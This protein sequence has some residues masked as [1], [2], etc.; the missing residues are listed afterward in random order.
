MSFV[1]P[2]PGFFSGLHQAPIHRRNKEKQHTK[3]KLRTRAPSS[4]SFFCKR[5]LFL[6][7]HWINSGCLL[8]N[9]PGAPDFC[10]MENIGCGAMFESP[11]AAHEF[12][13]NF[14]FNIFHPYDS[15]DAI[16]HPF[17]SWNKY[18]HSLHGNHQY[19]THH[20]CG[21]YRSPWVFYYSSPA[22]FY[23]PF[24]SLPNGFAVHRFHK[25]KTHLSLWYFH[26]GYRCYT[27]FTGKHMNT[28]WK[29][30]TAAGAAS[31]K[32]GDHGRTMKW[33]TAQLRS[34]LRDE[35]TSGHEPRRQSEGIRMRSH[36]N[37]RSAESIQ[38]R[39]CRYRQHRQ[40]SR[41]EYRIW[42]SCVRETGFYTLASLHGPSERVHVSTHHI[43]RAYP[44]HTHKPTLAS[45]AEIFQKYV[46]KSLIDL[47]PARQIPLR[48][49]LPTLTLHT[50]NI[51]NLIGLSKYEMLSNILQSHNVT[52]L[53]LQETKSTSSNEVTQGPFRYLLSGT[54]AEP[55]A[56]VGFAIHFSLLPFIHDFHPVS[57]RLAVLI[58]NV[59]PRKIALFTVYAPSQ[60]A[61]SHADFERKHRFWDDIC[62][63]TQEYSRQH[64]VLLMGDW[65]TR[66]YPDH[67]HGM[68]DHIGPVTFAPFR[69]DDDAVVHTNLYHMFD[70]LSATDTCIV[71]S[72]WPRPLS[73]L[74][75]Y[76]EIQ[77]PPDASIQDPSP[78]HFAV[79]DHI[80]CPRHF[81][82]KFKSIL[83]RPL[84]TLPW[85]HRHFLLE[86]SLV[87]PVFE[88][89]PTPM[90]APTLMCDTR[91][92][93]SKLAFQIQKQIDL[94]LPSHSSAPL[95]SITA[96]HYHLYTD[97]SCPMNFSAI[98]NPAGWGWALFA[99]EIVDGYGPVGSGLPF[100]IPGSNN[101][102]ELQAPLEAFDYLFR[103]P[104]TLPVLVCFDSQYVLDILEGISVPESHLALIDLLFAALSHTLGLVP[105]SFSKVQ[106]HTGIPGN[107]RAD[108]NAAKGV[109]SLAPV[110][111]YVTVPAL[112]VLVRSPNIPSSFSSASISQQADHL[113]RIL[114]SASVA[115][116]PKK[117]IEVRKPYLSSNTLQLIS[118][119]TPSQQDPAQL[120][121]RKVI[122]KSAKRDRKRWLLSQISFDHRPGT[123]NQWR[124]I[125]FLRSVYQPRTKQVRF[126][127]GQLS[128]ANSKAEALAQHLASTVWNPVPLPPLDTTPLYEPQSCNLQPFSMSE[129]YR[130]LRRAKR[131][132][133]PGPDSISMDWIVFSP[134]QFKHLLLAHYN[135]CFFAADAP[136]NWRMARVAMIYKGK[137]K[138][139]KQ[140]GS[141]RAISLA[142]SLYK[143]YA[144]MLQH[145]LASA[146]DYILSPHQFGFRKSRSA[147]TPIFLV[148]RLL[149][150]FERRTAPL[151]LL[152][153]DW[154]QA[155]DSVSRE[156]VRVS[157]LRYG[158][159][160]AIV[161]PIMA[162]FSDGQFYVQ[163]GGILSATYSQQR[164][165]RQGCPLSPYL[166][167]VLLSAIMADVSIQFQQTYG[168]T[169]W[170]H[171][172]RHPLN[173]LEFADDTVLISRSHTSLHRLLHILQFQASKRGLLL[174]PDKCQLLKL[175][176]DSDI[177]LSNTFSPSQPCQCPHCGGEDPLPPPCQVIDHP[178]YLGILLDS[179]S[180]SAPDC[181]NRVGKA[182]AAFR[183]LFPLF[184]N[185]SISIK[186]RLQVHSQ[187]VLAILLYGS[188]SQTF[189]PAQIQKYNALHFKVLRQI[190][191]MK[192][193]F[194]HRVLSPSQAECSNVFLAQQAASHL[195]GLL[196]PSQL[197]SQKRLQFL[198]HILRDPFCLEH[199]MIFG[200]SHSFL[201]L[202]SPFRR[203][204]PR[205][206][207]PELAFTE[208]YHRIQSF[209]SRTRPPTHDFLNPHFRTATL[210]L[211]KHYQ[212]SSMPSW[213]DNTRQ[214]RS[215]FPFSQ[216]RSDWANLVNPYS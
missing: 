215:I 28:L 108:A 178:T 49:P 115:S 58:L 190:L 157:L 26:K 170:S 91:L 44:A 43:R 17:S 101:T 132:K 201:R 62:E 97:G 99:T 167:I 151:F 207:W 135:A 183:S 87:L 193:S 81:R 112:P 197:I 77:A 142:N 118:Q 155:F 96:P 90:R 133:A 104:P 80:V 114:H 35:T 32:P 180:S 194:Y 136:D 211:H 94:A 33:L 124:T 174:N 86:A 203:G 47:P 117:P 123:S 156:A 120:H 196:T 171:S 12:S 98:G 38:R 61:D 68:T 31:G 22:C 200:P 148:R 159:P 162:L 143:L 191:G 8:H 126:P 160:E 179:T 129:L 176:A 161:N 147:S 172:S 205:A 145:R 213:F 202:S 166:F 102:A 165:I 23:Q 206:H 125:K 9:G 55:H 212:G 131:G 210:D 76:R 83:S 186:R 137:G 214:F 64:T 158:L 39:L 150:H 163:D 139:S 5:C 209:S 199:Q 141:Y 10:W 110:G 66:L 2:N 53:C 79:L 72:F 41:Q 198:G 89:K 74:I 92:L 175:N 71:S 184:S 15:F 21:C 46:R 95:D 75:T 4:N 182:T 6:L 173:H 45:H 50:W 149:E 37:L 30:I 11:L 140:A 25:C 7:I 54:P 63:I 116:L 189:S 154:Q 34:N 187:I 103:F 181:S 138:D 146:I 27:S 65:N 40:A 185:T 107:E 177:S 93:K 13:D 29:Y 3:A 127:N 67:L 216:N 52:L 188:E 84:A 134:L 168:Y 121:L 69:G 195:P 128:T 60:L 51:E 109:T 56:G 1:L 144:S 70:F 82:S 18:M 42:S 100:T 169:P 48:F 78:A 113:S 88:H 130:A 14:Y 164:G 204:A 152:F 19:H 57:G 111:R 85:F 36:Q 106:S 192:S 24:F 20:C 122:K 59:K 153:L 119:I 16:V 105:L 208:A 73:K